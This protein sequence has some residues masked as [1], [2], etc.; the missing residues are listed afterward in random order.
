M[1]C[2]YEV[3]WS[4]HLPTERNK[5]KIEAEWSL[6]RESTHGK[7]PAV[8]ESGHYR[9]VVVKEDHCILILF[10]N[11]KYERLPTHITIITSHLYQNEYI[12]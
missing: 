11:I 10:I 1:A 9:G 7:W 3:Q 8:W 2:F 6:Y 12:Y 5:E 4:P